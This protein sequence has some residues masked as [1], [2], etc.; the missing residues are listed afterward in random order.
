MMPDAGLGTAVADSAKK[1]NAAM[2]QTPPPPHE[3]SAPQRAASETSL[4]RCGDATRTG[5]T[6]SAGRYR[7]PRPCFT[8]RHWLPHASSHSILKWQIPFL[9]KDIERIRHE[10]LGKR[11]N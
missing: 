3:T 2:P 4:L 6:M 10:Y 5:S 8:A 9:G 7:Q 1:P 11:A